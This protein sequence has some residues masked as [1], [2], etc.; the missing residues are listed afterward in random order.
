MTGIEALGLFNWKS[1]V[2][3]RTTSG[4]VT[5]HLRTLGSIQD[6][7]RTDGS[8]AASRLV[9]AR[10]EN[11]DSSHYA[12]HISP[13]NELGRRGLRGI[14]SRLQR[15][16]FV[17]DSRWAV[18]P[19]ANPEPPQ[20]VLDGTKIVSRPDIE[21]MTEWKDTEDSLRRELEKNRAEWVKE[22]MDALEEELAKMKIGELEEIAIGLHQLSIMDRA[23]NK[24]WDYQTIFHGSYKDKKCTKPFW[25]E[26]S[27]VR[28][29]PKYIFS[30][31][32]AAYRELDEYSYNLEKL[33]NLS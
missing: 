1:S 21:D 8:M 10:L 16:L 3:L 15:S 18:E 29:L 7:L 33:K 23:W 5:V 13:L 19:Y 28:E 24:E 22:R 30:Q 25:K 31:V 17:R 11:T 27:E 9:Q 14:V 12:T 6:E 2:D 4:S 20:D 32:A 26:V